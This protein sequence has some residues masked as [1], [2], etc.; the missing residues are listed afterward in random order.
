MINIMKYLREFIIGSSFPVVVLFYRSVYMIIQKKKLENPDYFNTLPD[1]EIPFLWNKLWPGNYEYYSY[2]RYTITAP[3]YFGLW[4]I[5]SLIISHNF[6]L[7]FRMRFIT[8]SI[9]SS[10]FMM[11]FQTIYNIYGFETKQEFYKYYLHIFVKYMLVW[12]LIIYNL[13]KYI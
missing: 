8:I 5:L 12:N 6:N 11:V 4:N 3:I 10:I 2:F 7:S 9:L 13:E 1:K